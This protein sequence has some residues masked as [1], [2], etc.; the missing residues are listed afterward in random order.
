MSAQARREMQRSTLL[1]ITPPIFFPEKENGRCD[2]PKERRFPLQASNSK[3]CSAC[4]LHCPARGI[5]AFHIAIRLDLLLL[6]AAALPILQKYS[7]I[8]VY[9]WCQSRRRAKQSRPRP[10]HLPQK[11][12]SEAMPPMRRQS[13]ARLPSLARYGV[14]AVD[15]GNDSQKTRGEATYTAPTLRSACS[16]SSCKLPMSGV[17]G[18]AP[19]PSLGDTKGV[20]SSRREY[21]LCLTVALSAALSMQRNAL[22]P[23][24][25]REGGSKGDTSSRREYPFFRQ[26]RK[27]LH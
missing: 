5:A 3:R 20:F 21:P 15:T 23:P 12:A 6:P 16:P 13:A 10:P 25:P 11:A 4:R 7:L 19:R 24:I 18:N 26:Q 17:E 2:R 14:R 22:H 9:R 1:P 27:E 8:P